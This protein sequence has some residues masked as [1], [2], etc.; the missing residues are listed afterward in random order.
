MNKDWKFWWT[1]P[2][3]LFLVVTAAGLAGQAHA[4]MGDAVAIERA[5]CSTLSEYPSAAGVAGIG[6]ALE[7]QGASS[8]EAAEVIVLSVHDYCPGYMPLLERIAAQYG[9]SGEQVA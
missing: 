7:E 6:K 9:D 4:D 1:M 8:R 3:A 2:L 5:V